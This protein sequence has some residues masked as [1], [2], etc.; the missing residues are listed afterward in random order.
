MSSPKTHHLRD[1]IF[2]IKSSFCTFIKLILNYLIE[3]KI[4]EAELSILFRHTFYIDV[5][6]IGMNLSVHDVTCIR[7]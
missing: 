3:K 6:G 7:L 4:N 2:C 5:I 1:S